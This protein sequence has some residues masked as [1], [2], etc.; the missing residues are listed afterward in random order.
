MPPLIIGGGPAGSAAAIALARHGVHAT[1]IER[2]RDVRDAICGG[3]LSWRTLDTLK[4]LG[5]EPKG[6]PVGSLAL[7]SGTRQA[8]VPLPS[9]ATG[10][11]RRALDTL[12][13]EK[14]VT[15]GAAM[16]HATVRDIAGHDVHLTDGATLTND[17]IF[18]ASGKHDVRGVARPRDDAD[19]A[20]GLRIRI[21]PHPRLSALVG[22]AIE[23]HLF[24]RG[25]AGLVLQEDGSANLCL[26]VRKSRL[27]EAGGRPDMLLREIG[28]GTSLGDRL[29]F[30]DV[31]APDAIAAVP[32]GWRAEATTTGVFRLGDQ[33]AVIASLA[34]EGIGIAVASA[35]AAADAY[36]R[37]GSGAALDYQ[38][39]F[40][41]QT[42]RP[43]GI[44]STLW[45]A[46]ER[47]V[48]A[49]IAIPFLGMVPGLANLAATLTR[50]GH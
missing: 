25:Y 22:D 37:D 39:A 45:H 32:Y 5:L 44:A 2:D 46:A 36:A 8:R 17:A 48:L 23:L 12:M 21:A 50:V 11:S 47:P 24:D 35:L 20:L 49:G 3:F 30:A 41:R 13:R 34:G 26:A 16:E 28:N 27:A 43:V 40:A 31:I 33:A 1:I 6:H 14:A 29:A 42:R 4:L 10:L 19:P 15:T 9:R 38:R 7:F 18:L